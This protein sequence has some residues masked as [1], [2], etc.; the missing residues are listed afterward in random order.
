M[1]ALLIAFL[2]QETWIIIWMFTYLKFLMLENL[3]LF[4]GDYNA[5]VP[6]KDRFTRNNADY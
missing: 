6:E 3:Q 1:S 5:H 2:L 4:D